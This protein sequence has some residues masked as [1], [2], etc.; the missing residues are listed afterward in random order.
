MKLR[1]IILPAF[2][3]LFLGSVYLL[4][5]AGDMA[6][7]A[8]SMEL[9]GAFGDWQLR[10]I[11][12]SK[13]EIETLAKDTEFSKAECY[14]AR[15]FEFFPD[16]NAVPDILNLSIV[17]SGKDLNNSIHRPER[18]MVAQGHVILS[19]TDRTLK[20]EG[21]REV[22]V[23]RLM[24]RQRISTIQD[25]PQQLDLNCLTYYFFVG[26]DRI[27][28]DH[29][30]RTLLDM[31]DRLIHGRD[32]RWAYV[33]ASMWY[34]DIPWIKDKPVTEE[35]A[36]RKLSEFVSQFADKQIDWDQVAP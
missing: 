22:T 34:G 10:N 26:N 30:Q 8:V 17:L 33:S 28:N 25:P 13:V 31:K 23:K 7:S 24:S 20:S 15:E 11:P 35:E 36:E 4:P 5:T 19:S 9:P 21:G 14:R 6:Q 29:L 1:P 16:G 32:Q 3:L 2:A 27:T 12:A 18:C